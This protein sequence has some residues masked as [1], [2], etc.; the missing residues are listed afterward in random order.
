M[1]NRIGRRDLYFWGVPSSSMYHRT[2]TDLNTYSDQNM[3]LFCIWGH[4]GWVVSLWVLLV[5][6]DETVCLQMRSVSRNSLVWVQKLFIAYG[7]KFT[8]SS[9]KKKKKKTPK[10]SYPIYLII[11]KDN[12][13]KH[14]RHFPLWKVI[15]IGPYSFESSILF[16]FLMFSGGRRNQSFRRK[17]QKR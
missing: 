16:F 8:E 17:G 2:K 13:V 10:Q 15:V 9:K 7:A 6:W 3:L 5:N 12:L 11:L 1:A 14:S 4:Q